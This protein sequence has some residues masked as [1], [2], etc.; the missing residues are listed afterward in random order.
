MSMVLKEA[1]VYQAFIA[2]APYL[3]NYMLKLTLDPESA[4]DLVQEAFVR[5]LL[6]EHFPPYPRAWLARTGYRLFVDQWRRKQRES[7]ESPN[8]EPADWMTPEQALLDREFEDRV[9]R[10][11]LRLHPKTREVF[12][13]RIYDQLSY[14]EIANRLNCSENTVKTCVRRG[15]AK[16]AKWLSDSTAV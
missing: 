14:V 3:R 11:L 10:L 13:L 9:N 8:T 5:L 12:R 16:L 15:R 2:H 7:R 4:A 1:Q 6:Q